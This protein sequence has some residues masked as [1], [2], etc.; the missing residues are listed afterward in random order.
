MLLL[1]LLHWWVRR[2]NSHGRHC[3]CGKRKPRVHA[4]RWRQ[5]SGESFETETVFGAVNGAEGLAWT[6]ISTWPVSLYLV[7]ASNESQELTGLLIR[8]VIRRLYRLVLPDL[9]TY[10][11]GDAF[12]LA[13][14]A[15]SIWGLTVYHFYSYPTA[16]SHLL[17]LK[18]ARSSMQSGWYDRLWVEGKTGSQRDK[19]LYT[20]LSE[21]CCRSPENIHLHASE[22]CG[23][24]PWRLTLRWEWNRSLTSM[25][26]DAGTV[27]YDEKLANKGLE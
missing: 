3:S 21:A 12:I 10:T 5:N 7:G 24:L 19:F 27:Q 18:I 26:S 17:R 1:A 6:N 2:R 13:K 14:L 15:S 25:I 9:R 23:L 16:T 11:S 20:C 4:R 8:L 22:L